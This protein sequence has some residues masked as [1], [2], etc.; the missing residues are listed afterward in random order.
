MTDGTD[1]DDGASA[2]LIG[3]LAEHG[4]FGHA[5]EKIKIIET[6]ISWVLLTGDY[7]YKIKKPV[8]LGFLDFSTLDARHEY[9]LLEIELNRRFAPE[10]YLDVVSIGGDPDQPAIGATPALE[11]AVRMRQFPADARLD[12]QIE[13]DRISVEDMR[14]FG[15]SLALLHDRS[16]TL[17]DPGDPHGTAATISG[18]VKDNFTV[19]CECCTDADTG[20]RLSALSAWCERTLAR[21]AATIEKRRSTERVR[22]CH[23][24]LHLENLVWFDERIAPFDCL[25]FDARLRRIDVMNEVA[26]LLMDTIRIGRQDLGYAFLNRY[27]E[28]SGDYPGTAVLPFY[29]VYRCLVRAKVAAL[30]HDQKHDR[31]EDVARYIEL[32]EQLTGRDRSPCLVVCRGLSGSGKTY[33]SRKLLS[34]LPAIHIRSDVV[35][36]HAHRIDELESSGSAIGAG[37]YEPA[38]TRQTYETLARFAI[39][40]LTAGYDVIVDATFLRRMDRSLLQSVADR[41]AAPY[42][43]LDCIADDRI[44]A[45]RIRTR[46]AT[47]SDASEADLSVLEWQRANLDPL[48]AEEQRRTV[49]IDT[50][51]HW[52]AS[53]II[54]QIRAIVSEA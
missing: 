19:L 5:T 39:D 17:S 12:R 36:K 30:R 51:R 27:L 18:P 37:L 31:R 40:A 25:E 20:S 53:D 33:L 23:G 49:T 21:L 41:L 6:H 26:F 14:A 4:E 3:R 7:A 28:V 54:R 46:L 16:P 48:S 43:I 44:L 50:G 1:N 8:D 10:L 22:E 24:D 47:G 9:C 38:K 11:W 15:E 13:L 32:A 35:R 42:V 29:C 45:E 34:H 52:A 2:R